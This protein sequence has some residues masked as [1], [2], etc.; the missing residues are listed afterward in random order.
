MMLFTIR[1]SAILLVVMIS[2]GDIVWLIKSSKMQDCVLITG[3]SILWKF[4]IQ[5]NLY[6]HAN[7][8]LQ[9]ESTCKEKFFAVIICGNPHLF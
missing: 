9:A 7:E 6:L 1:H 3:P 8:P 5:M 4:Y 2:V